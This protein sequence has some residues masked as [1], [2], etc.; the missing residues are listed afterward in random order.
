[1]GLFQDVPYRFDVV[2]VKGEISVVVVDPKCDAVGKAFPLVNILKYA[3]FAL[4]VEF[5]DTVRL[6][7]LLRFE[8]KLF[9]DF[10]LNRN[11]VR[12]PPSFPAH[13]VATH[14]AV[15]RYRILEGPALEMVDSWQTICRRRTLIENE[16][17][18]RGW[19]SQRFLENSALLPPC[20]SFFFPLGD[21][22]F[23]F[24]FGHFSYPSRKIIS[25]L[26][27]EHLKATGRF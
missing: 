12:V 18:F 7:V 25:F 13:V 11:P 17:A 27:R 2:V 10:K 4:R 15:A 8:S 19:F 6:D 14:R 5:R 21:I 24:I 16:F 26:E 1:M 9:F 23:F 22:T 20:E 3:L